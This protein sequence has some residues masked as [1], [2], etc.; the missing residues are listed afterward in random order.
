MQHRTIG[1]MV[2]Y[3]TIRQKDTPKSIIEK[4][5]V[6][7]QK[8]FSDFEVY[9]GEATEFL[10]VKL[11]IPISVSGK[12][13]VYMM[14]NIDRYTLDSNTLISNNFEANITVLP[15]C[16]LVATSLNES[17]GS[18]LMGGDTLIISYKVRNVEIGK[19]RGAWYDALYLTK[20]PTVTT[21]DIRYVYLVWQEKVNCL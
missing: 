6:I 2:S 13:F 10:N 3:C 14:H 5:I 19:A 21:T 1:G 12:W 4:G 7:G 15:P 17:L 8:Y 18:P 11:V 16:D 20:Y 9:C